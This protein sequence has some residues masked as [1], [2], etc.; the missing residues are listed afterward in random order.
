[1]KNIILIGPMGSGKTT[2]GKQLAKKLRLDFID[3]DLEIEK[4]TGVS[5]STI[6][7]IEGEEGFRARETKMLEELCAKNGIVLA[8]GG[9][10]ITK[11]E[12]RILLRKSGYV[13]Y[14]KTSIETQYKRT[15]KSSNR[16]LLED[17]DALKK[18]QQL[19][20]EREGL[21]EQEADFVISSGERAVSKVVHEISE[22]I[23]GL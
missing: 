18:L 20:Q 4:R 1:M 5:I 2:V 21:Y 10:A 8:T 22:Q 12:N 6:F 23:N 17:G 7:D 16:P 13:V 9:G 11:E 3:A 15:Q 19:M 14:L